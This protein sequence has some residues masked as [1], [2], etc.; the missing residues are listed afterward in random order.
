MEIMLKLTHFSK[1]C[2]L[3][4]KYFVLVLMKTV[5]Q[6]PVFQLCKEHPPWRCEQKEATA[7][8]SSSTQSV[9]ARGTHGMCVPYT[10]DNCRLSNRYHSRWNL[11]RAGC[12]S[13]PWCCRPLLPGRHQSHPQRWRRSPRGRAQ[14]RE[15][16]PVH[17]R[18]IYSVSL[19]TVRLHHCTS[20]TEL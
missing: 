6:K 20:C 7:P 15:T 9:T 11:Q 16:G 19:P 14:P 17:K 4:K 12:I 2:H 8:D 1:H 5:L 18:F 10:Q 13:Q 3:L